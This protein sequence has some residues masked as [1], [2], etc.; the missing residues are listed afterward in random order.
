MA[1]LLTLTNSWPTRK[2]ALGE[3]LIEAG[4]AGGELYILVSGALRVTRDGVDL[5]RIAEPG[6][7]VGEMSVVLGL[8]HSATVTATEPTEVR[9]QEDGLRW[10]ESTPLAAL[11][12]AT[13]A[14]Q[15]LDR[16]SAL[17][18]EL[19]KDAEG[20][21]EAGFLER[22]FGAVTGADVRG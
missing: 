5:A 18:V 11:H 12:L 4:E 6:A 13:L 15:R 3:T 22:L 7:L 19:R 9:V 1:N 2:L 20:N 8:D 16:T 17:L 14:C 10:L 21:R